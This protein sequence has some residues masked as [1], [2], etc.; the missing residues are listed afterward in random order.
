VAKRF[1]VCTKTKVELSKRFE[2]I[3]KLTKEEQ[4]FKAP[5]QTSQGHYLIGG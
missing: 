2:V 3:Q 1:I 4:T 5:D